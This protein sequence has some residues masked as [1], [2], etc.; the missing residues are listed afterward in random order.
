MID[1]LGSVAVN[2]ELALMCGFLFAACLLFGTIAWVAMN[3]LEDDLEGFTRYVEK[4][5]A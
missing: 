3:Y 4:Q 5:G 1:A 2:K